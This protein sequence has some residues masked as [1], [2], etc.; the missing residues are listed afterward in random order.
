MPSIIITGANRGLGLEF[1]RQY[2]ADDWRVFACCRKPQGAKELRAL[3]KQHKN[4]TV[5]GVDVADHR[6][7][8]ALAGDMSPEKI[9]VLINNAGVYHDGAF[10]QLDY[11]TWIE[12]F[13]IN[14]FAAAMMAEAFVAQVGRSEQRLIVAITSLMGSIEDNTSGGS[15]LYRS[16]KTALNSVMKSLSVDLKPRGIGALVLHPGWVKTDMGGAGGQITPEESVRGMRSVIERFTLKDT[17]HF[18]NYD[19]RELPW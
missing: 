15:Y 16:S 7:I 11:H 5:H 14:T 10:G 12:S 13:R 17:G 8:D 6:Q 18:L 9:D 1:A 3:E 4:L 2:A 19:G